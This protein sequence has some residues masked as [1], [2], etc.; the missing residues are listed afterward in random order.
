MEQV[1]TKQQDNIFKF[2]YSNSQIKCKWSKQSHLKTGDC[3][4]GPN[5]VN[6]YIF[7]K[8]MKKTHHAK[9]NQKKAVA[10]I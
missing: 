5:Y 6:V 8:K 10:V 3:K 2:K 9:T 4:I 1:E 7:L